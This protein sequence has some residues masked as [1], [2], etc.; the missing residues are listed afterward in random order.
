M[1][2]FS[3]VIPLFNKDKYIRKAI[4][5]VLKQTFVDFEIIIIDDG[6]TDKS[7]EIVEQFED[8]RIK[9]IRQENSGVSLTRNKGVELAQS[10][11]IAFLDAD[12]WWDENF[13]SEMALMIK[14]FPEAKIF[15]CSYYKVKFAK[16]IPANIGVEL[17]FKKG[18]ID[19]CEV[20]SKTFWVPVNCSFVVL[21][22]KAFMEEKGF[23][24]QLKFGEDLDL[25]LRF[26]LKHKFAFL[27]K[28]LAYSNQDVAA[29]N[30][31]LG[32]KIWKKEEHVLFQISYL[33]A[34]EQN[35]QSLKYLLD[36]LR[37]RSLHVYFRKKINRGEVSEIIS[38]VDFSKH[39]F[40]YYFYYK[41]PRFL[42][43]SFFSLKLIGSKIKK[44]I[45]SK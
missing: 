1:A 37:I 39:D 17:D 6:S 10:D 18:Y 25:W 22:R 26:Y 15:S 35:N 43:E 4:D 27:N 8:E 9:L 32:D 21:E 30:R 19:Y 23:N 16:N 3:V 33:K 13:L 38:D 11:F 5:S 20:Y 42:T 34:N 40:I 28:T 12:D 29:D 45:K 31:A 14:E 2:L 24:P 36:G 44:Y 41:F 7:V